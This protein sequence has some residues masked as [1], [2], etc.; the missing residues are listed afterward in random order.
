MAKLRRNAE[1]VLSQLKEN[2][3]G[4]IIAKLPMV[5]QVP[6]RFSEIGLGEIGINTF[7]YG[8]LAIILESGDYAVLNVNA[9]LELNP[10][11]LSI[12]TVDDVDYHQFHFDAGD[13]VIK[14]TD[15]VKREAMLFN[16]FNEFIFN[17]KVPWY[18]DYED[19]GKLFDTAK[20]HAGSNVAQNPEV[21]EFIASMVSRSKNDRTKY[22]R[23]VAQ[24]QSDFTLNDIDYVPLKS[25]YW[26]VTST[27]NKLTGSHFA[28]GVTSALVT[29]TTKTD[30]IERILRA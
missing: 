12:V 27:V 6:V 24:K 15:L 7:T 13:V 22:I 30:K 2:S 3:A 5:I 25:V 11:K 14:T 8:L 10:Y 18:T 23:S 29:P 1:L 28:D 4:Q 17:G 26:S 21:I 9:L 16:V 20:Y 19:L